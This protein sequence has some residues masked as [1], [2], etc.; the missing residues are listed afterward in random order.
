MA[1][2][3]LRSILEELE[4]L[5]VEHLK[6]IFRDNFTGKSYQIFQSRDMM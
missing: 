4:P 1:Y 6:Y 5:D 3:I 2:D